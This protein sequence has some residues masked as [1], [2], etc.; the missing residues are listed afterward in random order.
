MPAGI[1]VLAAGSSW[2]QPDCMLAKSPCSALSLEPVLLYIVFAVPR[3]TI[4]AVV[5]QPDAT[6]D[7]HVHIGALSITIPAC[8]AARRQDGQPAMGAHAAFQKVKKCH[9]L[10]QL[11]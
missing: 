9:R 2:R 5:S 1:L 8:A 7:S 10:C 11:F 6:P 3:E 4:I